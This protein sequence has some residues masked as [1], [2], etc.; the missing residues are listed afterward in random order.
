MRTKGQ[1]RLVGS[2]VKIPLEREWHSYARVL[3]EPLCAF[4][5]CRTRADLTVEEIV[6]KDVLFRLWV[7][8]RALTSGRW[9]IVGKAPL[10]DGQL[11]AVPFFKQDALDPRKVSIYL[12]GK[13]R[14]AT[15]AECSGLERAAVWD[16]EH[17]E[18]RLRDHYLGQPNKWTQSLRLRV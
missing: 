8:N 16:P 4:Y 14:P 15:P 17:V 7:M 9:E 12:D 1:R 11:V 13:E 5:D 18:D 10:S 2:V 3:P 6:L